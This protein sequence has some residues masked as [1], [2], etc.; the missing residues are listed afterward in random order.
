MGNFSKLSQKKRL[1]QTWEKAFSKTTNSSATRRQGCAVVSSM[2]VLCFCSVLVAYNALPI[3]A[4]AIPRK[5][6][7]VFTY[8]MLCVYVCV[9]TAAA[10]AA[11]CGAT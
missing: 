1:F 4:G 9:C 5:Y 6:A 11:V 8:A 2:Q 7:C 10:A 3:H